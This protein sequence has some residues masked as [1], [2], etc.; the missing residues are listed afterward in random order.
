MHQISVTVLSMLVEPC[1]H[2]S[3]LQAHEGV[4]PMHCANADLPIRLYCVLRDTMLCFNAALSAFASMREV[5]DVYMFAA[6]FGLVD[7]LQQLA[8][9]QPVSEWPSKVCSAAAAHNRSDNLAWLRS[10]DP[11]CPWDAATCTAAAKNGHLGMLRWL[12]RQRPPCPWDA[13]TCAAAAG[14]GRTD[15]LVWLRAQSPPC[16]WDEASC[17]AAVSEGRVKT[18]DWLLK[19]QPPCPLDPAATAASTA[20]AQ[21]SQPDPLQQLQ[22]QHC[23]DSTAKA[24]VAAAEHVSRQRTEQLVANIP[25]E[26][27]IDFR[28]AQ[29][30]LEELS[31]EAPP[32]LGKPT[33]FGAL[34]AACEWL[35]GFRQLEEICSIRPA[36][37]FPLEAH[38]QEANAGHVECLEYLHHQCRAGQRSESGWHFLLVV[39]VAHTGIAIGRD[40]VAFWAIAHDSSTLPYLVFIAAIL[41]RPGIT[42]FLHSRGLLTENFVRPSLLYWALCCPAYMGD[43]KALAAVEDVL[44]ATS[45]FNTCFAAVHLALDPVAGRPSHQICFPPDV[46]EHYWHGSDNRPNHVSVAIWLM[47]RLS[48]F[49][50]LWLRLAQRHSQS[51]LVIY[52]AVHTSSQCHQTDISWTPEL[53]SLAAAHAELRV[54]R[55][56]VAGQDMPAEHTTVHPNCGGAR[57]LLLVH[58]HGWHVPDGLRAEFSLAESCR[59]AFFAVVCRQRRQQSMEARLSDLPDELIKRIA[60]QAEVDFS[61]RYSPPGEPQPLENCS[62]MAVQRKL[63]ELD[64]SDVV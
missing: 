30:G 34:A 46:V 40:E 11:P 36:C 58:G 5:E 51:L 45:A 14:E 44:K 3:H 9:H 64:D 12:R 24:A 23:A 22:S 52:M 20:A 53:H 21:S 8:L 62:D 54:V 42:S 63:A 60:C 56:L 43:L 55:W 2:D 10:R 41:R 38:L 50:A 37:Q 19:Q 27:D 4:L 39:L 33:Y 6:E 47:P 57:M 29:T 61:W 16:P 32:D 49:R 48:N 31:K 18:L 35:S 1:L 13:T 7:L 17:T 59:T 15:L 26:S 25:T 28:H